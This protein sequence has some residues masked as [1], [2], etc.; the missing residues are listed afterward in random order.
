LQRQVKKRKKEKYHLFNS[1]LAL[2]LVTVLLDTD[3]LVVVLLINV[4]YLK[5]KNLLLSLESLT[6]WKV[7]AEFFEINPIY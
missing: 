7:Y 3:M 1:I 4:K 6:K 5:C 2:M